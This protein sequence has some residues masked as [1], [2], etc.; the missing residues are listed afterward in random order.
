MRHVCNLKMMTPFFYYIVYAYIFCQYLRFKTDTVLTRR[1]R[2]N[3][4]KRISRNQKKE[5]HMIDEVIVDTI[6]KVTIL[7]LQ[8]NIMRH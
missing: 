4:K 6:S 3:R 2:L 7:I 5:E 1:L 8:Y